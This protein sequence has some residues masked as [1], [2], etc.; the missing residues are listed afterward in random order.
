MEPEVK[1]KFNWKRLLLFTFI[2]L[3]ISALSGI[4]V[5]L[6]SKNQKDQAVNDIQK[7][8]DDLKAQEDAKAKKSS[9]EKPTA[10][11]QKI[12][13]AKKEVVPIYA[14]DWY[15]FISPNYGFSFRYPKTGIDAIATGQPTKACSNPLKVTDHFTNDEFE[16]ANKLSAFWIYGEFFGLAVRPADQSIASYI[17]SQDPTGYRSY[18][19]I[20]VTGAKEAVSIDPQTTRP[21][22]G[23]PPLS[24]THYILN[25]G[26]N[27]YMLMSF[28]SNGFSG[29]CAP[30]DLLG[31][32]GQIIGTWNF[33]N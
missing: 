10:S 11:N 1:E 30:K 27:L 7:R 6:W 26:K 17:K 19:S 20:S 4:G 8:L 21:Y 22:D 32:M 13:T 24:Y 28:Q 2:V 33:Y 16:K 9:S 5:Y 23:Y 14:N 12:S 3:I 29:D 15:K 25:D 31:T 18:K